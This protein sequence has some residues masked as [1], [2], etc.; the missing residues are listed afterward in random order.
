MFI[1]DFKIF[2]SISLKNT[3]LIKIALN[4]HIVVFTMVTFIILKMAFIVLWDVFYIYVTSWWFYFYL[5]MYVASTCVCMQI[6]T[7]IRPEEDISCYSLPCYFEAG[8]QLGPPFS[9]SLGYRHVYP[10]LALPWC[11][12]FKFRVSHLHRKKSIPTDTSVC[13]YCYGF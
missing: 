12:G 5:C 7:H 13:H 4:L 1:Y 2:L 8:S 6:Y 11:W 9:S 10:Y 3:L